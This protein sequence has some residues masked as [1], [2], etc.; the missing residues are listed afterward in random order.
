MFNV[1]D[2]VR[3]KRD[4]E[5][6]SYSGLGF[7]Y[8]MKQYRGRVFKI[9]Y[10]NDNN[11]YRLENV[12]EW[13]WNDDMLESISEEVYNMERDRIYCADCGR[14][15]TSD[16]EKYE[17]EGGNRIV[18]EECYEHYSECEHCGEMVHEDDMRVVG[19]YND[20][21]VCESCRDNYYTYYRSY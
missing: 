9:E 16:D 8:D 21:Y 18:C 20:T 7:V 1:G 4:L 13:Y 17:V 5:E 19:R 12:D 15:I 6:R 14:E 3:V 11:R 2:F 10:K